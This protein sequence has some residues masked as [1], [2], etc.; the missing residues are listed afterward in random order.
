MS[1]RVLKQNEVKPTFYEHY[2]QL[3]PKG[4][5]SIIAGTGGSGKST[6]L[7]WLA[8]YLSH[9]GSAVIV[10]NEEAAGVISSR[11]EPDTDV[12]IISFS[13]NY[14][15]MKIELSDMEEI[16]ERYDI[17]LVDSLITFNEGK[18]INK[19]GT[20][21]AFLS[22]FVAKVVGTNKAVVFLHHTNKG[23]GN[24]RQ[25]MV[26]GSERLVSGVRH[27]DL[28]V[29][30]KINDRRYFIPAKDNTGL[31]GADYEIISREKKLGNGKTVRV[32]DRLV[33]TREDV[34]KIIYLNSRNAKIKQWD[35][36]MFAM[37][38]E[39]QPPSPPASIARV[40][41][42][43]KGAN[44]TPDE[45]KAISENEYKYFNNSVKNTGDEWVVKDKNAGRTTYKWTEKALEW[46]ENQ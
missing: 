18:D 9:E 35:K 39:E 31:D 42:S 5:V 15:A 4:A 17:V 38:K 6:F 43:T 34:D 13:E 27:C 37:A 2:G 23:G 14:D 21:E 11:F 33:E 36:E 16:I 8:S 41:K 10:S 22:P 40:L 19:S 20:A 3:I 7:C 28:L 32:V 26:T 29:W 25:D 46:L 44:T 12:D 45:V 24:S 30:D 1:F